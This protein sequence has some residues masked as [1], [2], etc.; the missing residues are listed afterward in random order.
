MEEITNSVTYG[1]GFLLSVVGL[2]ILVVLASRHGDIWRLV[3]FSIYG[4]AEDNYEAIC[5]GAR[6]ALVKMREEK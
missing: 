1:I 2:V 3:S 4:G 6:N 5:V